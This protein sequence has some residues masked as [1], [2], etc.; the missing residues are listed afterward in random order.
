MLVECL[1]LIFECVFQLPFFLS[2]LSV[3]DI[4]LGS[5]LP[6]VHHASDP[7]VDERGL[8]V[9]LDLSY[10]GTFHMTLETKLNLQRFKPDSEETLFTD[11][12]TK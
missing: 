9:D 12:L 5:A 1:F 8:W 4:H 10:N 7:C 3:R 11:D 2:E 6:K